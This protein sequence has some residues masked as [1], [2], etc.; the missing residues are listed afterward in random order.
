MESQKNPDQLKRG[1]HV[2]R[3]GVQSTFI[4]PYAGLRV[5]MIW[6]NCHFF[7]WHVFS[8]EKSRRCE[9][10]QH[11]TV[12]H[13]GE[14][15]RLHLESSKTKRQH[16]CYMSNKR[17]NFHFTR[18]YTQTRGVIHSDTHLSFHWIFRASDTQ[19]VKLFLKFNLDTLCQ[20]CFLGRHFSCMLC[21]CI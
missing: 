18:W 4:C 16:Y 19:L 7:F 11:T 1:I 17:S 5:L 12:T 8:F 3:I 15:L 6:A 2:D 14:N 9:D 21:C 13:F 10:N 20:L